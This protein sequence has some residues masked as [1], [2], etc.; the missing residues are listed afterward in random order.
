MEKR[1]LLNKTMNLSHA[2]DPEAQVRSSGVQEKERRKKKIPSLSP[3]RSTCHLP[4]QTTYSANPKYRAETRY[5]RYD[6]NRVPD[7]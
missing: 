4:S 1:A 7:F 3:W 2:P 5:N 6:I